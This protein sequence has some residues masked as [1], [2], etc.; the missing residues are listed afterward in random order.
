MLGLCC[1][2]LSLVGSLGA[3]LHAVHGLLLAVACPVDGVQALGSW[4]QELW[5]AALVAPWHVGSSGAG[6]E[7]VSSV[8]AEGVTRRP[9]AGQIWTRGCGSLCG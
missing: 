1:C 8:L 5:C 2:R 9:S 6:V 3:A 4:L 7:P